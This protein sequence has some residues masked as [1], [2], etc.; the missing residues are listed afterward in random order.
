MIVAA[1]TNVLIAALVAK[2]LC[3][4]VV[5]H[6]IRERSLVTSIALLDELADTLHAKFE[7]TSAGR[8][9]Y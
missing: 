2:G 5:T 9:P 8:W 7:V 4:E 3:S 1:D 6:A